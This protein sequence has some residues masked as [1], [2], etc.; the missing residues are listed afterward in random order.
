MLYLKYYKFVHYGICEE[1]H[2]LEGT[3]FPF[4]I[5]C[6]N[7]HIYIFKTFEYTQFLER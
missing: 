3:T 2:N 6:S 4:F 1:L 5:L 7:T